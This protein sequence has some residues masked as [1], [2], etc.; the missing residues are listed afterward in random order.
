MLERLDRGRS[1]LLVLVLAAYVG[2]RVFALFM[3]GYSFVASIVISL[4]LWLFYRN[5]VR[6]KRRWI[7]FAAIVAAN[8]IAVLL[9]KRYQGGSYPLSPLPVFRTM[10]LDLRTLVAPTQVQWI[11]SVL[12]WTT[13]TTR[14][15]GDGSNSAYNYVGIACVVLAISG[16][17]T[18]FGPALLCAGVIALVV[19]LGPALKVDDVRPAGSL[20]TNSAYAMPAQAATLELPWGNLFTKIPGLNETRAPYRWFGVTRLMLLM[21]AALGIERGLRRDRLRVVVLAL[22]IVGTLELLP[23]FPALGKTY[24]AQNTYV[25]TLT[26]SVGHELRELTHPG[27]FVFFLNIDPSEDDFLVN[28]LAPYAGVRT[29]NAGGDKNVYLAI[30]RWPPQLLALATPPA[31]PT[32]VYTALADRD[33]NVILAPLFDLNAAAFAW[34]PTAAE[35]A[36]ALRRY[37]AIFNDPRFTVQRRR[38]MVAIRLRGSA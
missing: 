33:V 21:L 37:R 13:D 6:S 25:R 38:W 3:D 8:G 18:R 26:E 7:E 19:A 31:T 12:G 36:Q 17:R 32:A 24:R 34:P 10:G 15:W 30:Q 27:D 22:A 1:R 20:A 4:S 14:F 35:R 29:Y 23:N 5:D 16:V 11:P 9:Y 28:Y 2:V